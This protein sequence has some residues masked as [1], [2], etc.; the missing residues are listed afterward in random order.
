MVLWGSNLPWI[1]L[2]VSCLHLFPTKCWRKSHIFSLTCLHPAPLFHLRQNHE[3]GGMQGGRVLC[4]NLVEVFVSIMREQ[5]WQRKRNDWCWCSYFLRT[6]ISCEG[7]CRNGTSRNKTYLTL[8]L[9]GNVPSYFV[10]NQIL[11]KQFRNKCELWCMAIF[12]GSGLRRTGQEA[13][14]SL[15]PGRNVCNSFAAF[16]KFAS[17]WRTL[18]EPPNDLPAT[19]IIPASIDVN[20]K[21][22]ISFRDV[23]HCWA[24]F[25]DDDV[26]KR[27]TSSRAADILSSNFQRIWS[28]CIG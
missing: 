5:V 11:I 15:P 1:L 19:S 7:A 24:A 10:R 27:G 14:N 22:E 20:S 16:M 12:I 6:R 3:K 21:E 8:C 23:E 28:A 9:C 25:W 26:A 4:L 18:L 2:R 13:M 17:A